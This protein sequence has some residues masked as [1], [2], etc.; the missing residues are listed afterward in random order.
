MEA[1]AKPLY[2]QM[3]GLQQQLNVLLHEVEETHN[4]YEICNDET[5]RHMNQVFFDISNAVDELKEI[6]NNQ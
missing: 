5:Y 3:S 2:D 4:D 6:L 1:A